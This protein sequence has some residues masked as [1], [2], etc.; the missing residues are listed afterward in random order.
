MK[1]LLVD[2]DRSQLL[3]WRKLFSGNPNVFCVEC[4]KVED[5]TYEIQMHDMQSGDIVFLDHHLSPNGNEGFKIVNITKNSG[6][7]I[8]ST[9]TDS[10]A[11]LWYRENRIKVISKEWK[12]IAEV[13]K[14]LEQ[15]EVRKAE[16]ARC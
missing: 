8:F 9:T 15:K 5:V 2:D 14:N 12:Q 11:V 3:I 10:N 16:I 6:I 4:H 13:I 7:T 1:F